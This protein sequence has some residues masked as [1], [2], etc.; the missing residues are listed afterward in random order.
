MSGLR[1][2]VTELTPEA[3]M[4][5]ARL[6]SGILNKPE[7]GIGWT[8]YTHIVQFGALSSWATVGAEAFERELRRRRMKVIEWRDCG[9]GVRW[10]RL[11]EES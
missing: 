7:V 2:H 11:E 10:S 3:A 1:Y 6:C 8:P 4:R 9:D 5:H